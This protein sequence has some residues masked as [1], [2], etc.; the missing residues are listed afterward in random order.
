MTV[1]PI[2]LY[3]YDI[4]LLLPQ[5]TL[6]LLPPRFWFVMTQTLYLN[7]ITNKNTNTRIGLGI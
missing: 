1:S 5:T 7:D 3:F 4:R 6:F 2:T